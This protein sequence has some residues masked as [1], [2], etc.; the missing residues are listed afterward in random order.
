MNKRLLEATMEGLFRKR[1]L[2]WNSKVYDEDNGVDFWINIARNEYDELD[3]INVR[4][5]FRDMFNKVIELL[6]DKTIKFIEIM[7]GI[8]NDIILVKGEENE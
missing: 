5:T 8:S 6:E 2:N 3:I 1:K 4:E 7:D